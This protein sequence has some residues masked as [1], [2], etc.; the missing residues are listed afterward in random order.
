MSIPDGPSIQIDNGDFTRIHNAI[1]DKLACMPL[2]G[3]QFRC[4]MFLFRKT[5]GF[6]K[7]ID[8]ISLSQWTEGTGIA[9]QHVWAILHSL[10]TAR[11]VYCE[12]NGPKRAMTWGFNKYHE[13]WNAPAADESV[14]ESGNS[15]DESVTNGGDSSVPESGNSSGQSVPVEGYETVPESGNYNKQKTVVAAA[16][17]APVSESPPTKD[18]F[19]EAYEKTW[20][21]IAA[22]EYEAGKIID[23]SRRV[24][25]EGWQYA[26]R[27]SADARKTD[28]KYAEAILRRIEREGYTP[29][30]APPVTV[31]VHVAYTLEDVYA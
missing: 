15:D 30:D 29:P 24:T 1:L 11:I 19:V 20:G 4:L 9:R 27:E 31:S 10:Q 21:R 13:Q 17:P 7:K 28:W 3:R 8:K 6:N 12:S 26:L 25:L 5:Y 22:S 2:S 18:P 14:P 23:W 16:A